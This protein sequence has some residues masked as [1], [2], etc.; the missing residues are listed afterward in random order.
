MISFHEFIFSLI[1]CRLPF[2]EFEVGFL[3][4]L[5]ISPSQFHPV[6]LS[7]VKV[8]KHCVNIMGTSHLWHFFHLFKVQSSANFIN[9]FGMLLRKN[10]KYLET[11]FDIMKHLK[12]CFFLVASLNQDSHAKV[13]RLESG[14]SSTCA[15][16]F[17]KYWN[18][19]HFLIGIRMY[20]HQ[21]ENFSKEELYLKSQLVAL[22]HELGHVGGFGPSD[23]ES[24]THLKKFIQIH[25]LVNV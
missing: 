25:W 18:Q 24:I 11:Y 14:A 17:R 9:D 3:N 5:L 1:G 22:Y 23:L 16:I 12:D 7:F 10:V 2:N 21:K 15:Y 6:S 4:H 8:F 20:R 19:S 13:F